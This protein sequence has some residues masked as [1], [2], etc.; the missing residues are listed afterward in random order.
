MRR[1]LFSLLAMSFM[2][3]VLGC[4]CMHGVCDCSCDFDEPCGC[5]SCGCTAGIMGDVVPPGVV[6]M[7][8]QAPGGEPLPKAPNKL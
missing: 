7:P 2:G 8:M 5:T 6:P 4:H 3:A 1:L